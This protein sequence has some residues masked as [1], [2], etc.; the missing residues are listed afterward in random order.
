MLI[1][2]EKSKKCTAYEPIWL[3]TPDK[4]TIEVGKTIHFTLG[5]YLKNAMVLCEIISNDELV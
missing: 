4:T 3:T 2:D 5:S 1:Y